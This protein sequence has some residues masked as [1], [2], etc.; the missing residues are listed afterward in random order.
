MLRLLC[1]LVL[2]GLL[3]LACLSFQAR[4]ED[5]PESWA[6]EWQA[7]M[8]LVVSWQLPYLWGGESREEGGY[9]CSGFL[10][11]TSPQMF[12]KQRS[13]S[14]R[15]ER[16][17]DGW[18][19]RP[20]SIWRVTRLSLIFIDGHVLAIIVNESGLFVVCHSRSSKGPVIER[21]PSWIARKHPR[22]KIQQIG[23]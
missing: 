13:T 5:L 10:Q 23:D 1:T 16:G 6:A 9:D 21:Y 15:M 8:E 20:V 17:L 7:N 12:R 22:F 19:N 11:A 3:S 18:K 2:S 14:E 4:S